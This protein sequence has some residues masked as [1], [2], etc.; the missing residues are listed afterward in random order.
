M[1][2]RSCVCVCVCVC[3]GQFS[4]GALEEGQGPGSGLSLS[5][6]PCV[7]LICKGPLKSPSPARIWTLE[8]RWVIIT[9]WSEHRPRQ[10][11]AI[12]KERPAQDGTVLPEGWRKEFPGR[13]AWPLSLCPERGHL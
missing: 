6:T 3:G 1:L 2:F 8:S 4:V 10:A 12:R 7:G 11:G 13:L 9:V 5:W